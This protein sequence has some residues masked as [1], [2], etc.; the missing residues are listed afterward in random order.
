MLRPFFRVGASKLAVYGQHPAWSFALERTVETSMGQ[1]FDDLCGVGMI[2][3]ERCPRE[4][5]RE[6]PAPRRR[7]VLAACVLASSMAFIDSSVL[8]VALPSL[9]AAFGADL[10]NVQ[11]VMNGYLLALA[12]LTLIGGALADAHGNARMLAIGCLMFGAVS[13]ACALAPSAGW[14]IGARVIQGIAA[15]LL[16]PASL[17]LIGA[18]YP[19][20]ERAGAIGVWAAAAALTSAAGPV[21]GGWL[22][23][24][25]GWQAVFWINPPLAIVA[26]TLLW[27]SAP[28]DRKEPHRFDFV[29][30]TLIALS[31]GVLTWSLSRIGHSEP[32][33][34]SA[35]APDIGAVAAGGLGLAG[36]GVYV[37][38]ERVSAHPM[39]PPRLAQNRAFVGLNAATLLIYAGLAIVFFWLP[40]ELVDRRGLS[41]ASVGLAFLPFALGVGLLSRFFGGLA[42][43]VGA[44][45]MLVAGAVCASATYIWMALAQG[46]ALIPSV[47]APQAVLG[48]SFA[49]LAAPLTASVLSS[50]TTSDQGLASGI[51][52]A[53]GRVAQLA[54]VALAAGLGTLSSGWQWGLFAAAAL[55][56]AGA[57]TMALEVP[58]G[59]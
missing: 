34:A 48:I 46:G 27:V 33:A 35:L 17:A 5:G 4:S 51:N 7:V 45:R 24:R 49:M 42:D 14:L 58:Q 1:P 30:A 26:V 50:V 59:R 56:A 2:S 18:T 54:G 9:R 47:L 20:D 52:N 55:S 13:A 40:F 8:T 37:T 28:A 22:T 31:L 38:W 11:W 44:G 25:F 6:I 57:L 15:A 19:K 39:T 21:A 12:A 53:I 10:A 32:R 29:G 36:L 3:A 43:A 16:T 23:G 41:P